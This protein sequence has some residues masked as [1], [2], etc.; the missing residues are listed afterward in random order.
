MKATRLGRLF[1]YVDDDGER[2][3]KLEDEWNGEGPYST[4]WSHWVEDRRDH[5][6]TY[7]RSYTEVGFAAT[8]SYAEEGEWS[9]TKKERVQYAAWT[10]HLKFLVFSL[11]LRIKW[12]TS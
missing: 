7:L 4:I 1:T 2:R 11:Y 6:L 12:A 9:Y 8:A 3:S 10:F 5:E